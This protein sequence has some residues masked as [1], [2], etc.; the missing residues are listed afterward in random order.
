MGRI[1]TN[2]GSVGRGAAGR[3]SPPARGFV[4]FEV[5]VAMTIL[6]TSL[7]I[8]MQGFTLAMQTIRANQ[9]TALAT[10]LA[11]RLLDVYEF[12]PPEEGQDEGHFGETYPEYTW[13][14]EVWIEKSE[15]DDSRAGAAD[16]DFQSVIMVRLQIFRDTTKDRREV[17]LDVFSALT[18]FERFSA[19]T[20]ARCGLYRHEQN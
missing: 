13:R 3:A 14:R 11:Q 7:A 9:Q 15:Y 16:N 2:S 1:G 5:L 10:V 8:I 6:A 19:Q 12:E 20:R 4:L 17:V 18:Q